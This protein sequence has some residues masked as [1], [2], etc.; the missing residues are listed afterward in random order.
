MMAADEPL[1][2]LLKVNEGYFISEGVVDRIIEKYP[3]L[4]QIFENAIKVKSGYYMN[5]Y[6]TV[7]LANYIQNTKNENVRLQALSNQLNNSLQEEREAVQLLINE[8]DNVIE[9]Q[10]EQI[11][12]LKELYRN[13]DPDV[14]EK[15]GWAAGGAGIAAV[16]ILLSNI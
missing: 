6:T 15:V 9:L 16:L 4:E 1:D 12:N 10:Q 3:K 14:F 8:K 5:D 11:A 13:K 2:N 7:E